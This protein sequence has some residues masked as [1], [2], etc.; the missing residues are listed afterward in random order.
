[1][2]GAARGHQ[3]STL[4]GVGAT[5]RTLALPVIATAAVLAE[6]DTRIPINLPGHRGLL[7]LS[8]LV[9]VA[10]LARP[11]GTATAVGAASSLLAVT[12]GVDP[13]TALRYAAAAALLD[14]VLAIPLVRRHPILLAPAAAPIHLVALTTQ[15]LHGVALPQLGG[16]ALAHLGFGLAAGL[17]GWTLATAARPE[18]DGTDDGS[19]T[20]PGRRRG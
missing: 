15:V 14:A 18:H 20:T 7:W 3:V 8:V 11:R 13:V 5:L 17:L 2:D 9:A 19:P 4:P 1:M 6:A 12:M 10:L 16:L